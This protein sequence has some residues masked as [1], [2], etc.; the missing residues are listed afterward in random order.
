MLYVPPGFAQGFCVL[1]DEALVLYKTTANY[2]RNRNEGSGGIPHVVDVAEA[3]C[4]VATSSLDRSGE[5]WVW[6]AG[7]CPRGGDTDCRCHWSARLAAIR[8]LISQ[9]PPTRRWC[10][11]TSRNCRRFGNRGLAYRTDCAK[12]SSGGD[13]NGERTDADRRCAGRTYSTKPNRL[14]NGQ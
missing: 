14:L 7:H 13:T 4:A 1:S 11:R 5:H 10:W 9:R 12:R 6:S 8:R 3:L 2:A